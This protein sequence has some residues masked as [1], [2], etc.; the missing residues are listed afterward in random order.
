MQQSHSEKQDAPMPPLWTWQSDKINKAYEKYRCKGVAE[1][2]AQECKAFT[3]AQAKEHCRNVRLK[4][5]S[6]VARKGASMTGIIDGT[7][8]ILA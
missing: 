7:A 2:L 3:E 5:T 4:A 1:Q 6:G 8:N